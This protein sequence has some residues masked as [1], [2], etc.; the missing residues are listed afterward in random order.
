[1]VVEQQML[2]GERVIEESDEIIEVDTLGT[3]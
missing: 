2:A 3:E 1:M